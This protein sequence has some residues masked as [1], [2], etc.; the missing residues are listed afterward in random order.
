MNIGFRVG[1]NIGGLGKWIVL[2][3]SVVV[4]G[5]LV[6]IGGGWGVFVGYVVLGLRFFL[7]V[8]LGCL[9]VG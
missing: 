9:G 3:W 5:G 4:V 1:L 7:G 6:S 8:V 2:D